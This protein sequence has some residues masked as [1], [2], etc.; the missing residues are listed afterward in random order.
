VSAPKRLLIVYH[1]QTG[2]TRQLA[3]A[4]ARGAR[5]VGSVEVFLRTAAQTDADAVLGADGYIFATPENLASMSGQLKDFFDRTY[6]AALEQL[7]GRP[8]LALI[9]AGSDGRNAAAQI[10]RIATGWRLKAVAPP[11]IILTRATTPAQIAAPKALEA[12]ALA[13][14]EELGTTLAA[15]LELG[16]F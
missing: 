14:G 7:N 15:G 3:E 13:R 9:C 5:R 4:A 11:T 1:S 10:E 6:Y 2:A 8:Y 16:V 12:E